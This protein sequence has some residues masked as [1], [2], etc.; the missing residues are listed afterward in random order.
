MAT[1]SYNQLIEVFRRISLRHSQIKRFGNG[2]IEDVNIFGDK[3]P[4]FPILWVVPQSVDLKQNVL[5][6]KMRILVFDIDSTSDTYRV[7][8]L[9][10]T[11][12]ILNDVIKLLKEEQE[13]YFNNILIG[14]YTI[15]QDSTAFPFVQMFTE[16]CSG[17]YSDIMIETNQDNSLC[18]IPLVN[19]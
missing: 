5:I 3:T 15:R 8:I 4:E 2:V 16:Y 7:E 11:L 17:W 10:D 13:I 12:R 19:S 6:Y 1:T 18:D 9:S 14:D